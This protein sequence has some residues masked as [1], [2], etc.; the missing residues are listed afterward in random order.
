LHRGRHCRERSAIVEHRRAS[1]HD[2][3]PAVPERPTSSEYQLGPP[4]H[5]SCNNVRQS[6]GDAAWAIA[7][8]S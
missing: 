5:C 2:S 1:A 6:L 3:T 4:A 7:A 8:A